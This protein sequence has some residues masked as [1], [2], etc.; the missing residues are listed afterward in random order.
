MCG[1]CLTN[2]SASPILPKGESACN[3]KAKICQ[4]ATPGASNFLKFYV[5]LNIN[6]VSAMDS[7]AT[8]AIMDRL[9]DAA[10]DQLASLTPGELDLGQIARHADIRPPAAH[11]IAGSVT[12]LILHQLARLDRQAL[13]ESLA[14][15][16]DAGEVTIREKILESL[17]HRFEV[18]TPYKPQVAA[19][20]AAA[21]RDLQ[22]G[23]SLLGSLV[24][25]IRA[26]LRM[27]GDD[28]AGLRGE[29]RVRGVAIV[30][31]LVAREWQNDDSADLS[32]TMK[33]ID[34]RLAQ[35]EE[36]GRNLGVL[37]QVDEVHPQKMRQ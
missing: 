24:Q 33:A 31:M 35:A 29:A 10:W 11:A 37:G 17:M 4:E 13:I 15:I 18:Y 21:L 32:H 28:L 19:L 14:D 22:L 23:N 27:V 5:N 9:A 1:R 2:R 36:W 26:L 25:A 3:F 20:N 7:S 6:G 8:N 34:V 16:E 30:A 12:T